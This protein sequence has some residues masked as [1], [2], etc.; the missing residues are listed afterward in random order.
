MALHKILIGIL[1]LLMSYNLLGQN[2]DFLDMT[3]AHLESQKNGMMVLGAWGIGNAVI[4]SLGLYRSN[5]PESKAFHQMNL[6][7][8]IINTA[9]AGYGYFSAMQNV[10]LSGQP[11]DLLNANQSLKSILL[12]N[13]GLDVSY[14]IGGFYLIER[15]KSSIDMTERLKGFGKS[16]IL[17]GAFLFVFDVGMYLHFNKSTKDIIQLF[18]AQQ[19][20]GV[21]YKF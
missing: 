19:Q 16:L 10:N 14:I 13:T 6:G 18:S 17:Q 2:K 15:S 1:F 8:G 4:G 12:L 7:W 21:L 11:L 20:I 5:N 3:I 9:I